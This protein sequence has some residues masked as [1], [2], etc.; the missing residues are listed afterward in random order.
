MRTYIFAFLA[1]ASLLLS[2]AV[3]AQNEA[4]FGFEPDIVTNYILPDEQRNLGYVRVTIEVMVPS[5]E[6]LKTI[7]HHEALLRDA[8]IRI[9]SS[10]ERGTIR[11]LQGRENIRKACLDRARQLLT[12]EVGQPIVKDL[13]FT[14]YLYQ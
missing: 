14:K 5:V 10:Q 6:D 2:A 9:L 7:E 8:F 12:Q 11:T 4:Y 1:A 3:H 13:M